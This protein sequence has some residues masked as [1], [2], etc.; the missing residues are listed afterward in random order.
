MTSIR[1]IIKNIIPYGLIKQPNSDDFFLSESALY[2]DI[3]DSK[4]NKLSIYYLD[5]AHSYGSPYGLT[6]GFYPKTFLWDRFNRSLPIHFY[7]HE[8]MRNT[9]RW[10]NKKYGLLRESEQI[11]VDD[12]KWALNNPE[13]IYEFE[14]VF[15][16]SAEVLNKYS[17]AKFIP[18][19]GVW[20]GR[21]HTEE[22]NLIEIAKG[23]NKNICMISSDKTMCNIHKIRLELARKLDKE[24]N[25]DVYGN[26]VNKHLDS[27]DIA[28]NEYRYNIAIENDIKPYYFTEKL[29]DCFASKTVPIYMGATEIEKW[30]NMDGI[31]RLNL[32]DLDDIDKILKKC[33][34]N[35]YKERK[36]AIEDNYDRVKKFSCLE[37]Y[38]SDVYGF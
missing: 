18:A 24:S 26:A 7:S 2:P 38:L 30:F 32:N 17:N 6:L 13:Q 22:Q 20:Y 28:L 9:S 34:E 5:D 21:N 35:D 12:Y 11:A 19:N 8:A 15:T 27:K 31:I 29:L 14:T 16:H 37:Y 23:K 10:A 36:E 4:G 3:Y 25:V 33:N 1:K